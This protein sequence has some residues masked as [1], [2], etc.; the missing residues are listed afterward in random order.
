MGN[1]VIC[2]ER[3]KEWNEAFLTGNPNYNVCAV[4]K[5]ATVLTTDNRNLCEVYE[6][7]ENGNKISDKT[8]YVPFCKKH[9]D[10]RSRQEIKVDVKEFAK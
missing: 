4:S 9:S 2:T 10:I 1:H 6:C 3:H 8:Y 5:C 7:D